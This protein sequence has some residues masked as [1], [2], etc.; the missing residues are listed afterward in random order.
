MRLLTLHLCP[1]STPPVLVNDW[2]IIEFQLPFLLLR[3]RGKPVTP[4]RSRVFDVHER[5]SRV[6]ESPEEAAREAILVSHERS[7]PSWN[8]EVNLETLNNLGC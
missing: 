5:A 8:A 3:S 4:T 7:V 1:F 6:F 2:E